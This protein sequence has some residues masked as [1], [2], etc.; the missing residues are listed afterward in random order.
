M[1]DYIIVGGGTAGAILANRLSEN[2]E[3]QVLLIEA[4]KKDRKS[5][6]RIPAAFSKLFKTELDWEYYSTPQ[7]HADHRELY[8]PR[9]KMLGGCSNMNAMIYIRGNHEDYNHWSELGNQGW[10]YEEVLPY[11][12]KSE[13]NENGEDTYHGADGPMNVSNLVNPFPISKQLSRAAEQA[14]Y[15][16]NDDFN[17]E[18]Q[19]GFGLYQVNQ[20]NGRRVSTAYAYLRPI[21]NRKNLT[22]FTETL[23]RRIIIENGVATGVEYQVPNYV[24]VAK[25]KKE[26]ILCAGAYNSPQLLMLSGVGEKDMLNA[27]GVSVKHDLPGVGKNLQDHIIFPM[28]FHNRDKNTLEHAESLGNLVNYLIWG[29][30]ALS[31]NIAEGGGFVHTKPGLRG[32]DIQYHFAPGFFMNHGFDNPKHGHGFSIGPTLLQPM[33]IGEVRIESNSS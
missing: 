9:G 6:I 25:A 17:G 30:G 21:R 2:P 7:E 4:G 32:P 28:V 33:S 20:K 5:E 27:A 16:K 26:V 11:F 24:K 19:E 1:F 14:G 13:V 29:E 12:K 31:S 3:H 8:L 10:S 23:V 18:K 15:A 22:I